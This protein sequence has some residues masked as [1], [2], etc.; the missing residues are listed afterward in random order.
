MTHHHSQPKS[1]LRMSLAN[2]ISLPTTAYLVYCL[3]TQSLTHT[4]TAPILVSRL[5]RWE[6]NRDLSRAYLWRPSQVAS[7][8]DIQPSGVR[9]Q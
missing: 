6:I 5:N 2:I 4:K 3:G 7:E 8:V 9:L 1:R